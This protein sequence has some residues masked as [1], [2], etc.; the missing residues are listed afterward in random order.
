MLG[1]RHQ[2]ASLHSDFYW[3]QFR[4]MVRWT[5]GSLLINCILLAAIIYLILTK[6]V[7]RYYANT[8][9]GEV[10]LMPTPTI[11]AQ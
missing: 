6:P 4:K 9:D 2:I 10:L 1:Q 7:P 5:L 8:T 11:Q 3:N